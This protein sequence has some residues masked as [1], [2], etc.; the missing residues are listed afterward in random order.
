MSP[1]IRECENRQLDYFTL[2]TGQHYS[3]N[4][5]KL[6]F[7]ELKLPTPKYNL[8][9][10][11]EPNHRYHVQIMLDRMIAVLAAEA[12]NFVLVYGDTNTTL[13]AT[14]A[15]KRLKIKIAHIEAGLRSFDIIMAEEVNR[16]LTDHL[17]SLLFT[18]TQECSEHILNE[19]ILG[20]K[21]VLTGNTIVDAVTQNLPLA[22]KRKTLP[23]LEIKPK[24]YIL[25]T[26]HRPENVDI[27]ERLK[28]IIKALGKVYKRFGYKLVFSIHPRTQ[29][30]IEQFGIKLPAG[31]KIIEPQGY[32]DFLNLQANARLILTDSGGIQE[33]AC[34]LRV[35]C[36]TIRENT[37]RPETLPIGANILAGWEHEN[38]VKCVN[39]MLE[40]REC[41]WDNPYG[42]GESA[43][44]I[45][46][47]ILSK[48][49]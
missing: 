23:K 43:R 15:A 12:P 34:S 30:K 33:E 16:M 36:V 13:A 45:I 47:S 39:K 31:V 29:K 26:A 4:M 38:I 37:E 11:V 21:I 24:K 27:E 46:E 20:S 28:S 1:L 19:G 10:G 49:T 32:L 14:L 22:L 7:K 18:P 48:Q 42:N 40:I 41:L 2:H 5:D 3:H 17:S 44:I 25:V 35:P 8:G 9:V 6:F